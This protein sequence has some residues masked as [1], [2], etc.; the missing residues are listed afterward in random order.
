VQFVRSDA[1][2]EPAASRGTRAAQEPGP[3]AGQ[4]ESKQVVSISNFKKRKK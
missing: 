1:G 3:G 2:K 4:E